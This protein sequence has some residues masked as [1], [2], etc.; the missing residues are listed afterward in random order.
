MERMSYVKEYNFCMKNFRNRDDGLGFLR[1]YSDKFTLVPSWQKTVNELCQAGVDGT[2]SLRL[3]NISCCCCI[4]L[5]SREGDTLPY[6]I[7]T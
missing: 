2:C 4:N 3:L 5:L 1:C 7:L 6:S